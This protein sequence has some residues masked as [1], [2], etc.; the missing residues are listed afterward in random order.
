MSAA[1]GRLEELERRL[2][3]IR[4]KNDE[5]EAEIRERERV[6]ELEAKLLFEQNKARD[7]PHVQAAEDEHGQI[8][9]VNT[10]LGAVVVRKPHHLAFKRFMHKVS[11]DKE[12]READVWRLAK[13]CVVYPDI[14]KVDEIREEY[15]GVT[16]RLGTAVIELGNGEAE[17]LEGR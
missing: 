15:P 2:K 6:R 7:L 9:V 11:G 13:S 14:S 8:R 10:K 16:M 1:E 5:F 17:E 3:E 12:M 4:A